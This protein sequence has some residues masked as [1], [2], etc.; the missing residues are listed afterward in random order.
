MPVVA[1]TDT[2]KGKVRDLEEYFHGNILIFVNWVDHLIF[3]APVDIL[4]PANTKFSSVLSNNLPV[5]YGKHPDWEKVDFSKATWELNGQPFV[6]DPEKTLKEQG[7]DHKS[8]LKL[9]TPGLMGIG[10][11]S[12]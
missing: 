1:I 2:Y 11:N 7:I 4:L 8:F 5:C 12:Y 3:L 10:G 6:P 9:T